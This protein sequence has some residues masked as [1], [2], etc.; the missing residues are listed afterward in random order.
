MGY[1]VNVLYRFLT[2]SSVGEVSL[3][4]GANNMVCTILLLY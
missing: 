1:F 2:D 3:V 4:L